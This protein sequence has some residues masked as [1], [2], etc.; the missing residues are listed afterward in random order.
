[1]KEIEILKHEE[2]DSFFDE[3]IG[4]YKVLKQG[5]DDIVIIRNL[6][7]RSI[8]QIDVGTLDGNKKFIVETLTNNEKYIVK[9][10]DTLTSIAKKFNKSV[11]EIKSKNNLKIDKLFIGQIINI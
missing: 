11:E 1:M 5:M 10:L 2:I 3:K 7:Y 4:H 9:P 6:E 8:K